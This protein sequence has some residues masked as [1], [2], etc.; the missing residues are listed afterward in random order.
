MLGHPKGRFVVEIVRR[1]RIDRD[2]MVTKRG[3]ISLSSARDGC[4]MGLAL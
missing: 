2:G 3:A 1:V 4:R